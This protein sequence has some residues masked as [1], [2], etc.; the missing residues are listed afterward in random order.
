MTS[1]L[2]AAP[3]PGFLEAPSSILR[4]RSRVYHW[5]GAGPL[6]VKTFSG[7]EA[8]YE[9]GGGR[10]RVGEGAYL[11]LN[12]G[13]EYTITIESDRPVES[14]CVFFAPEFADAVDQSHRRT[15]DSLL[16]DPARVEG[17][18]LAF[19]ER[20]YPRDD[21]VSPALDELR[22]LPDDVSPVHREEVL[23]D[24]MDRLL[25][26]HGNVWREMERVPAARR[27][28]REEL[29]RRVA[30]ARELVLDQLDESVSLEEMGRVAALSPNHLLR[31]FRAVFGQSPHQFVMSERIRRSQALLERTNLPVTD[32]CLTVGMRS[33]GSFSALFRR[34]VGV[35]P[36]EYRAQFR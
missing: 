5:Q 3:D 35:T 18:S 26:L 22:D 2:D 32:I 29:Y 30:L 7:G 13:Q 31:T 23:H 24:L 36:S 14:F 11:I 21:L 19:V 27:A 25:Q 10:F 8:R 34:E 1:S 17:G 15:L 9:A 4:G 12:H 28:T 6:S 20:T 16:D 33:F